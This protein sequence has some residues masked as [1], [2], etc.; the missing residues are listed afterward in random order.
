MFLRGVGAVLRLHTVLRH[1]SRRPPQFFRVCVASR[2]MAAA[3]D[4]KK[5]EL[6]E[7][8]WKAKL[9][10][11]EYRILRNKGT[12]RAGTGQYNKCK[13]EGY[14]LVVYKFSCCSWHTFFPCFASFSGVH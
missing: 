12:E 4:L 2:N 7:S 8:E 1:L 14:A 9:T 11:E 13:D 10:P 3:A 6:S 5:V